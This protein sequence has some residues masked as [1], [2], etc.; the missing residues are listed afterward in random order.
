MVWDS[1]ESCSMCGV[2]QL[3]WKGAIQDPVW[4]WFYG[5]LGCTVATPKKSGDFTGFRGSSGIFCGVARWF[6]SSDG[7]VSVDMCYGPNISIVSN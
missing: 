2:T 5:F 1:G 7:W 4:F 6:S 3:F